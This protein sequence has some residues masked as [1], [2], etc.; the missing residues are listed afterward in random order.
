MFSFYAEAYIKS[1]PW[2][3]GF[4]A[5]GFLSINFVENS[6]QRLWMRQREPG[7]ELVI[8]GLIEPCAGDI[9]ELSTGHK[10]RQCERINGELGDRF[11][12]AGI[13]L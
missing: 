1:G 3:S 10:A 13:G 12:G 8:T 11:I 9:E 7:I 5:P 4:A 6:A 2:R